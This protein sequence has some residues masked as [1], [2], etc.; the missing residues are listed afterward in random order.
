VLL[1]PP[2]D[3]LTGELVIQA[4]RMRYGRSAPLAPATPPERAADSQPLAPVLSL[5]DLADGSS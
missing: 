3:E 4:S 2:A 1:G 5:L